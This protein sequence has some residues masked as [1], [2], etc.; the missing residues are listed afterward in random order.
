M[1]P[2]DVN[3]LFARA[4]RAFLDGRLDAARADLL[5][6]RRLAGAHPTVLHLLALVE[7][8]RGANEAARSAFEAALQAAPRD[9]GIHGNFANLLSEMG[10]FDAALEHYRRALAISPT[11][12]DVRF[13]RALLLH[14]CGRHGDALADLDR[15]A[16]VKPRDSKIQSARGGVLRALDRLG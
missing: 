8:R 10:E 3:S 16:A 9:A 6:V 12:V 7:S 2:G 15:L 13:N 11:F 14:K 5:Q 1:Q 4:E